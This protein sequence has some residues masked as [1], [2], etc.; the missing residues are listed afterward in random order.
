MF[1]E[2]GSLMM[3]IGSRSDFPPHLDLPVIDRMT[4]HVDMF[5]FQGIE[6]RLL[7]RGNWICTD[8]VFT[9]GC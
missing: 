3:I 1:T 7:Q 2:I 5:E 6:R 8:L 4:E 9:A